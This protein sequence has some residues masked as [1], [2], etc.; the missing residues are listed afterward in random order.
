MPTDP[1]PNA[2]LIL[3]VDD[4][5]LVRTFYRDA[6]ESDGYRVH[7]V[8]DAAEGRQWIAAQRPDLILLDIRMPDGNGLDFCEWVL[9]QKG[10]E[11][12][13]VIVNSAAAD[14]ET[15]GSAL[16]LGAAQFLRKPIS[17]QALKDA[18]GRVLRPPA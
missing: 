3:I 15:V 13:R 4:D 2:K 12:T 14:D 16:E 11:R 18:V 1:L 5:D 17:V 7:G 8:A 9:S 10:L 6:L